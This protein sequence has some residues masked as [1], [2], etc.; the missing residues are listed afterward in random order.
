LLCDTR[1]TLE[2]QFKK[3][4]IT[5]L[6]LNDKIIWM[7]MIK[8][9]LFDEFIHSYICHTSVIDSVLLFVYTWSNVEKIYKISHKNINN[10]ILIDQNQYNE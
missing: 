10:S 6:V 5:G 4:T 3:K 1:M 9:Q 2:L 8:G 7:T